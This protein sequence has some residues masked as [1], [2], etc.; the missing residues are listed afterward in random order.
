MKQTAGSAGAI[1]DQQVCFFG[2]TEFPLDRADAKDIAVAAQMHERD[3]S[4]P[5]LAV[6]LDGNE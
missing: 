4:L 6:Y 3:H 2:V 5:C 1:M